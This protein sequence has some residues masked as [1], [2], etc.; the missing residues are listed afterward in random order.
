M[1][2]VPVFSKLLRKISSFPMQ[3][4]TGA[5]DCGPA[6]VA[7]LLRFYGGE[8]DYAQVRTV[9]DVDRQGSSLLM[10]TQGARRLG[11]ETDSGKVSFDGLLATQSFPC[12]AYWPQGHFVVLVKATS[13][14]MWIADPAVGRMRMSREDFERCWLLTDEPRGIIVRPKGFTHPANADGVPAPSKP[15]PVWEAIRLQLQGRAPTL[16]MLLLLSIVFQLAAPLL[17]MQ[18]FSKGVLGHRLHLALLLACGQFAFLLGRWS[19]DAYQALFMSRL[20]VAVDQNQAVALLCKYISLPLSL[21]ETMQ[22]GDLIQRL[23]DQSVAVT[24]ILESLSQAMFAITS[25]LIL[26][27]LLAFLDFHLLSIAAL[28]AFMAILL[29]YLFSRR[30]R[31]ARYKLLRLSAE[32]QNGLIE[33]LD[34]ITDIKTH[35]AGESRLRMFQK[36]QEAVSKAA[37]TSKQLDSIR[38]VAS[39]TIVEAGSV[40]LSFLASRDILQGT[41][42]V[43]SLLALQFLLGQL[44]APLNQ[45]CAVLAH[46]PDVQVAELRVRQIYA[47]TSETSTNR[48][49]IPE[50]EVEVHHVA[51]SYKGTT[52]CAVLRDVSFSVGRV[53]VTAIVGE[54]GSG[55]S[56]LMRMLI[57]SY[58]PDSGHCSV[59]G[60]P[61]SQLNLEEWRAVCG[62]VLQDG[63]MFSDSLLSNIA[64][65]DPMPDFPEV[66]RA[67]RTACIGD[68]IDSLPRRYNTLVGRNGIGL[69]KGQMQRIF[70][71]RALYRNPRFLF[72][73]EATSALDSAT[74][75]RVVA[76]LN[77]CGDSMTSVVIAHRASS[78]VKANNVIV[79]GRGEVIEQGT[80]AELSAKRGEFARLFT[81]QHLHLEPAKDST[82]MV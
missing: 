60:V 81:N 76:N 3:H 9:L 16:L 47:L 57:G 33:M 1:K 63:Y 45:L 35:G 61:F 80:P 65:A 51:F 4:Q 2:S 15:S 26:S 20:S 30:Q 25:G 14:R 52:P 78:V 53:G 6:C 22:P 75:A 19:L 56:T 10:L 21:V 58:V 13:Q 12:I 77:A 24:F 59:A 72:L 43:G 41:M 46:L 69:S 68:F 55:K 5:T 82:V 73:D 29:S 11:L 79:L 32:R 40:S 49:S 17:S 67:A 44:F 39:S 23:Q 18:F 31:V 66:E 37:I 28:T 71:A 62:V 36:T 8:V 64:L 54:S 34:G 38:R 42:S 27:G 48:G 7:M 74:E 70:L 50:G